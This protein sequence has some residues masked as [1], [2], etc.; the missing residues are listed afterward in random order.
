M[1]L[2]SK[3]IDG[4]SVILLWWAGIGLTLFGLVESIFDPNSKM[5]SAH[6]IEISYLN[7]IG[8]FGVAFLGSFGK[9]TFVHYY[10]FLHR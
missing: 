6:I 8:Y 2:F 4:P 7:W 3:D 9:L 10:L 5:I 1:K